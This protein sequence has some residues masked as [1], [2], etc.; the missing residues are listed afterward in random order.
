MQELIQEL[1]KRVSGE[2]RFDKYSRIL[3][4]T[5]ASVYQIEPRGVVIPKSAD[6]V[7]AVVE[8]ARKYEVPITPRGGGTS[9]VGQSI[10]PGIIV[11]FSKYM[12]AILEVNREESWARIQPG[13]VLDQLNNHVA[14]Q[15]LFFGPDVATSSR[16]NLGGLVGNNSSGARSIVY[17]KTINHVLELDVVFSDSSLA[18]LRPTERHLSSGKEPCNFHDSVFAK[19]LQIA[20]QNAAEIERRFPKILRR[21][22]GYNLDE[23][24]NNENVNLSNI[25][26]GAEGTLAVV[27]EIKV[28]LVPK[29]EHRVLGIVHFHGLLEAL[30]AVNPILEF[31]PSA[32]ELIDEIIINQTRGTMEYA[33]RMTFVEGKPAALLIVE[34]QGESRV[35]IKDRLAKLVAHLKLQKVGYAH[36][37]AMDEAEQADVWFIRKAGLGLLL[38]TRAA[39]RPIG[40]VEDTAVDTDHLADYIREFDQIIKEHKTEACY[41]AHA[42][43]GLLHIRPMLDLKSKPDVA[44]MQSIAEAVS[45]LVL[46]YGGAF[47]GEHGDGLARSS[48]NE[49]MFGPQLYQA[50]RQLKQAFDPRNILN[51]GKIVDAQGLTENL[52]CED[53][54]AY[55]V[56][57]FL[58]FSAEGGFE[59]AIEMCNGNGVCRQRQAG[60]MCPSFMVTA[61]EEQSTRGRANA[62]RAVLSG[63]LDASEFTSARMKEVFDLCIACKGCKGECPTNIDMAKVKYEFLHQY[64]QVHGLPL[65]DR[66]FG[67]VESLNKFGSAL[68]PF[69]NWLLERSAIR[70]LMQQTLG[71]SRRRSL[72]AF[73]AR[74]FDAWFSN[75]TDA[76]AASDRPKIALFSDTF[77]NYN[78]PEIGI[79]T[80]A[81]LEAAGYE[82]ITPKKEC[83]GRPFISRG[84]LAEA[85]SKAE[86]NLDLLYPLVEQGIPIV[87]CEPSCILTFREEYPDMLQDER[88]AKLAENTFLLEEFLT[89][90]RKHPQ[91]FCLREATGSFLLHG[92]CH[93]KALVGIEPTRKM[94]QMVPGA[95]VEVVDSACCGMAGS[96]G[97]EQEHYQVSLAMGGERL[98]KAVADKKDDWQVVAAGTS[99]RQQIE[100]GVGRKAMHPIEVLAAHLK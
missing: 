57:P 47:S 22:G 40:F 34:F 11:D 76:Q 16:A 18:R 25:V 49:K 2:V 83:C 44:N 36:V 99:C 39:R 48:F 13:V 17:G 82:V 28:N 46:K 20:E 1:R 50:F 15:G 41:Y 56:K 6:D 89:D 64:H 71:I 94:L 62:L 5:D 66:L 53:P 80:V 4:S 91:T 79:A 95:R 55:Q 100:H 96:F 19:T 68:A 60:A 52:R 38:G 97:Y 29:L 69:S 67:H 92:H 23:F 26:V 42:S 8:L 37:Q 72:P 14:A 88:V 70:W 78:N 93:V 85:K 21:V 73:A 58:D 63:R 24:A 45:S 43:V 12:N 54:A 81:V 59:T 90:G 98:F 65:R 32:V 51:P 87:G 75:R 3:Y 61:E 33:R 9:L 30:E 77:L 74:T 35:E 10:G 86:Q 27:T 31:E 7:Q 84:M